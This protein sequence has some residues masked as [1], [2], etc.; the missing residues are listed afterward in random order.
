MLPGFPEVGV[1]HFSPNMLQGKGITLTITSFMIPLNSTPGFATSPCLTII[2]AA[3][4]AI[5]E[6]KPY[7]PQMRDCK[8]LPRRL[9]TFL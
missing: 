8:E 5:V 2:P 4:K 6:N 1:C 3:L 9:L 7:T